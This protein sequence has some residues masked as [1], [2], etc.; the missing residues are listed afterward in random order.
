MSDHDLPDHPLLASLREEELA[1]VL[2]AAEVRTVADGTPLLRQGEATS[3]LHLVLDGRVGVEVDVDGVA[4]DVAVLGFG[5]V[6]GELSFLEQ[7]ERSTA[8]VRAVGEARIATLPPSTWPRLRE[9]DAF[10]LQLDAL[11]RRRRATNRALTVPPVDAGEVDGAPLTMRPLWP[12]DWRHFAAGTDRVSEHSLHLRF[13]HVPPLTER[14][15][16]RLTTVDLQHQ[17]AWGAFLHGQLVGVGRHALQAE[18]RGIAELALLVADDLHGKGVG[19]RLVAAIAAAAD[20]HGADELAA[21]ARAEN[22]GVHRLL[23]RYGAV[24]RGAEE[25]GTVEARWALA[26]ALER[27]RDPLLVA[28]ARAVAAQVLAEVVDP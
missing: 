12:E 23:E 10:T 16:R 6:V 21:L 7:D 18:D 27:A 11:A 1:V 19:T 22:H 28:R 8:D 26:T 24:W 2:D 4:H 25:D 17:F 15:F 13:F 3:G 20:A 5:S 9:V 14:T